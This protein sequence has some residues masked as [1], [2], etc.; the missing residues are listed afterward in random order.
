M[1]KS[2]SSQLSGYR[3]SVVNSQV[4]NL[5]E[6][7]DGRWRNERI[8]RNETWTFDGTTLTQTEIKTY[9]TEISSF[10]KPAMT[11]KA[12]TRC[13]IPTLFM[14]S[15]F[16]LSLTAAF[17]PA[18]SSPAERSGSSRSRS[19]DHHRADHDA[20]H[21]HQEHSRGYRNHDDD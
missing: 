4:A 14:A 6:F 18:W 20:K 10:R 5:Q 2:R 21:E 8:D 12:T 3:F 13:L 1:S 15:L 7:D 17:T 16:A 11:I 19:D 9:G